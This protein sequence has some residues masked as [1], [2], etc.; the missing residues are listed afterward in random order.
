MADFAGAL[1]P[2]LAVSRRAIR[3]RD[4]T[5]ERIENVARADLGCGS[6]ELIATA[7]S[8]C[9]RDESRLLQLF[10]Q[11]AHSRQRETRLLR[12]RGG[13]LQT[14]RFLRQCCQD[15][16]R[17]IGQA[18]DPKHGKSEIVEIGLV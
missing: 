8:T 1:E 10:E 15:Y 6:R 12:K 3:E 9:G 2:A 16:G 4:R 18:T 13:R 7:Q 14:L 17:V 5:L 11:L